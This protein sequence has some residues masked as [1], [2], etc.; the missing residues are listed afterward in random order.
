MARTNATA[1]RKAS[2]AS[3]A[4]AKP[5]SK[6]SPSTS[7]SITVRQIDNGYLVCRSQDGPKGYSYTEEYSPTKPV[8]EVPKAKT[9]PRNT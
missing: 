3:P 5:V 7:V 6:L 9:P 8:I 1:L 2:G 4:R